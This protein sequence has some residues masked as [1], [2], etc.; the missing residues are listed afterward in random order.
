MR[1]HRTAVPTRVTQVLATAVAVGLVAT[2]AACSTEEKAA[3]SGPVTGGTL[4]L[5]TVFNNNQLDPAREASVTANMA[6]HAV[7]DTLLTFEG[8][9]LTPKPALATSHTVSPDA[10][11]F[12][13][14]LRKDV[15]FSDGTP[16]T[17]RDVVFSFHRLINI[18]GRQSYMLHGVTASAPEAHV[19]VLTSDTPNPALERIV[20]STPLSVVNSTL[21]GAN[22]GSD[23]ADADKTDN[24]EAFLSTKS[25]GSGPYVIKEYRP[26][27]QITLGANPH[28]WGTKPVFDTV[29]IR[30]VPAATQLLGVQRG[31]DEVAYDIAADQAASLSGNPA[32][33]VVTKPALNSFYL[34]VNI[35]PE[36]APVTAN[37]KIREAIRYGLDYDG[38]TE[39]GGT[40]AVQLAGMIPNGLLGGLPP[41]QAV[42]RDVE[43]AKAAV[44]ASGIA[45]PKFKL[46]YVANFVFAGVSVETIAQ[47]IQSSLG[48]IGLE[49][50]IEGRPIAVHLQLRR[51]GKVQASASLWSPDSADP[52]G[53]QP[54]APGGTVAVPLGYTVERAPAE[55]ALAREATATTD[56]RQRAQRYEELQRR[57][58]T[59]SPYFP[60]MQPASVLVGT[61]GLTGLVYNPQ[62]GVDVA[63]IGRG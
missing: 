14:N 27:Q 54:F 11:V 42:K 1:P 33:Q 9:D 23:A 37:P 19:V 38:I 61:A 25:A 28:Y 18:K 63:R 55:A 48:E 44:A 15:K 50:E 3:P 8:S 6:L 26:T 30:N 31:K 58:N 41:D 34:G 2:L 13:F 39:I 10:K 12:T 51:D 7:Y 32:V 47:K 45:D 21:V 16:L 24:A 4:V 40:G 22:G 17:A 53:Y 36:Q 46:N 52:N 43:R 49:V 56:E 5:N 29:I 35:D 57:F 60:L 20:A 59:D 62:W